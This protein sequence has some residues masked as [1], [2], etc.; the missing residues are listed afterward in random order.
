MC[1]HQPMSFW[2]IRESI[3]LFLLCENLIRY[4]TDMVNSPF[5][6]ANNKLNK[7]SWI[8]AEDTDFFR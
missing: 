4:L 3:S 8:M 6:R 7:Y 2:I 5:Q 1:I